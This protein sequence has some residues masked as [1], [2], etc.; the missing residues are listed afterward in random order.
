MSATTTSN[1]STHTSSTHG[2]V[3]QDLGSL[4]LGVLTRQEGAH[5]AVLY[6]S[7][8][9]GRGSWSVNPRPF[10]RCE[11]QRSRY[12]VCAPPRVFATVETHFP[13]AF[14]PVPN[15]CSNCAWLVCRRARHV[16]AG[17]V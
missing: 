13:N 16:L 9:K 4:L 12:G 10:R 14:E 2:L 6:S 11:L 17:F 7:G 1:G 5:G 15:L 8:M 3:H